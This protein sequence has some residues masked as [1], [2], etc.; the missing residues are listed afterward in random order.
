MRGFLPQVQ[1]VPAREE[2]SIK[3]LK[4]LLSCTHSFFFGLVMVLS[5]LI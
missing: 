2:T 1:D 5:V 4:F 3:F